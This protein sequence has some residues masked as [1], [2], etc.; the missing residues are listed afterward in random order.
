[1]PGLLHLTWDATWEGIECVHAEISVEKLLLTWFASQT[2]PWAK[3]HNPG[4]GVVQVI[5]SRS[6]DYLYAPGVRPL[7]S[8]ARVRQNGVKGTPSALPLKEETNDTR[9]RV[10]WRNSEENNKGPPQDSVKTWVIQIFQFTLASGRIKDRKT[11][12]AWACTTFQMIQFF[13]SLPK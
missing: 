3:P 10:G 7:V 6:P 2:H 1:M 9:I 8:P 11:H 13:F 4:D 5:R 12:T